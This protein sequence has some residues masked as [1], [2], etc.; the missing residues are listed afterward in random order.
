M[1]EER[2]TGGPAFPVMSDV[3]DMGLVNYHHAGMTLRDYF[4]AKCDVSVYQPYETFRVNRGKEPSAGE[5]AA[6]IAEIRK[7]EADAMLKAR[8]V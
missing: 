4:M 7:I 3:S 8:E 5:L 2:N 1:S 6:Y